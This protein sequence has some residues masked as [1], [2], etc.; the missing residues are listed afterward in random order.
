MNKS[1]EEWKDFYK[2]PVF[3]ITTIKKLSVDSFTGY[4]KNLIITSFAR[5]RVRRKIKLV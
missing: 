3:K 4:I 5:I 1:C 2:E